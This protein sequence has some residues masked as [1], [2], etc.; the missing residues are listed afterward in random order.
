MSMPAPPPD[1]RAAG[2]SGHIADHNLIADA[3]A[4]LDSDVGA[5]LLSQANPPLVPTV[6][7]TAAYTSSAYDFVPCDTSGG[8][9]TVK[10]PQAPADKV[11][12]GVKVVNVSG[13][14]ATV[15]V[16]A[17]GSDVFNR[18]GGPATAALTALGR[19]ATYQY[20]AAL[21]IWYTISDDM[22]EGAVAPTVA[23]AQP[24]SNGSTIT[25]PYALDTALCP[26]T[27]TA[28]VTGIILAVP[29]LG[30]AQKVL[31]VNRSNFTVT[32]AASGTSH[33]AD[34][35]SDVIPALASRL[36]I[37]DAGSGLWYRSA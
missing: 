3:L 20:S 11:Q 29:V 37:Y 32:F 21:Q 8:G 14:P 2:Q 17:Q 19:A 4:A 27:E 12:V 16:Q 33:V 23:A 5:L 35:V 25:A 6:V 31:I 13:T 22:P 10:L 36:F 15:T 28:S 30:N 7:K 26:V 34:G 24:L 18:T 1:T 9:F